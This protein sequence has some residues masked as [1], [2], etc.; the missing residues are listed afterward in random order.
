MKAHKV[1]DQIGI[2]YELVEQDNPT[3]NCDAAAKERGIKTCQIV[4]SLLV[5]RDGEKL[6]LCIPGDRKLSEKKFGEYRLLPSEESERITGFES[7]TIHPLSS[8]LK[9]FVDERVFENDKVSFTIGETL[10]GLIVSSKGFKKALQDQDFK[11]VV[12]DIVSVEEREIEQIK[13]KGL[14]EEEASFIVKNGYRKRF[15]ELENIYTAQEIFTVTKKLHRDIPDFSRDQ[16]S[17]ILDKA[18]NETHIQKLVEHLFTEGELPEENSFLLEETV[19]KTVEE[20]PEAVK[21]YRDGN[22]SSLN[23]LIGQIMQKT[24]GRADGEKTRKLLLSR[25][26]NNEY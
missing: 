23:Y 13:E 24:Q 16:A 2:E 22:T 20:N 21:D 15:L 14:S 19:E 17:K 4:K 8:D 26:D 5:K 7:G 1:L 3:K 12:Q 11:S 18:E 10:R 25:L 9:H 6:H